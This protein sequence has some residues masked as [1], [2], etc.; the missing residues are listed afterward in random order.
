MPF[1]ISANPKSL[2]PEEFVLKP[3]TAQIVAEGHEMS[4]S[5]M[6][7]APAGTAAFIAVKALP[8][9]LAR[10]MAGAPAIEA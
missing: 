6:F 4:L 9:H 5:V 10:S 8:F 2:V 7:A 1:H 3:A